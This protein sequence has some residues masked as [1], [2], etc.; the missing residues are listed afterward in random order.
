MTNHFS[1]LRTFVLL[2]VF[3]GCVIIEL[4][5]YMRK[6]LNDSRKK[7]VKKF[8]RRWIDK[9]YEKDKSQKFGIEPL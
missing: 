3:S 4:Y 5:F 6:Q 8:V 9:S 2:N 7:S 1:N